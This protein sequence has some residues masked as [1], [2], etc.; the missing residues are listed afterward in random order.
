MFL[1]IAG[2]HHVEQS[3]IKGV[4]IL[5]DP[6]II[7]LISMGEIIMQYSS[8]LTIAIHILLCIVEFEK[9]EKVTSNFLAGSIGVNPVIIRNVLG[10]LQNANLIKT[11]AGVGGSTLAKEPTDINMLDIFKA[12]ENSNVDLFHFHD[13]PNP[14]C[15][16]GRTV[17]AVLDDKL[18]AIQKSMENSMRSVTL[19]SL[20]TDMKKRQ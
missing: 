3:G 17:H 12:V 9:K 11:A 7:I 1:R 4:K 14:E 16:V 13:N 6:N 2:A 8:R 20:I 15:P 18:A 5:F 10:Q 19:Q